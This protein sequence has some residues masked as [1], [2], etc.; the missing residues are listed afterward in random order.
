MLD[1]T[2]GFKATVEYNNN[3]VPLIHISLN[4]EYGF[5]SYL[6]FSWTTK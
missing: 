5:A 3:F 6:A 2:D 4:S 1:C